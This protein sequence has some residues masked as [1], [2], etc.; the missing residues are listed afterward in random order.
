MLRRIAPVALRATSCLRAPTP[1][2]YRPFSSSL[3]RRSD[4]LPSLLED[5]S[6]PLEITTVLRS[7]KGFKIRSLQDPEPH[8]I[9]ANII[10]LDGE[11]FLWRPKLQSPQTG[12]LDIS[13]DAWGILDVISPKPG[14]VLS[15][16]DGLIERN[17][18]IGNGG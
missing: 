10:L 7:G 2:I 18:G 4:P 3:L 1:C 15:T 17:S 5:V 6:S 13:P 8:T 16:L 11:Y 12:I 14:T 9:Y